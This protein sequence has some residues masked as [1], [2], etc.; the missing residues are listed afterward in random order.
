MASKSS[1]SFVFISIIVIEAAVLLCLVPSETIK[2]NI[3]TEYQLLVSQMG[4]EYTDSIL[5]KSNQRFKSHLE[6][7]KILQS[8]KEHLIPNEKYQGE[9]LQGTNWWFNYIDD[10]FNALSSEYYQFLVRFAVL[11]SWLPYFLLILIPSIYDGV[12]SWM[13]TR[14]SY[15]YASPLMHQ[16][17][18][19]MVTWIIFLGFLL[20]VSPIMLNPTYIPA[21]VLLF[22]ILL[23]VLVANRQKRI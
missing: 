7:T 4:E 16:I 18:T 13:I 5:D 17:S 19:R 20:F 23:G 15:S 1:F 14:V 9:N 6:D 12:M 22:C 2:K 10:R 21:S 8:V 3:K 11:E